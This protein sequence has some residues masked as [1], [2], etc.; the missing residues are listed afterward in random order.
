MT[1][2]NYYYKNINSLASSLSLSKFN[3]KSQT[4]SLIFPYD[5]KLSFNNEDKLNLIQAYKRNDMIL[6]ATIVLNDD[7][8]KIEYLNINNDYYSKKFNEIK[9]LTD[10]EY[11]LLKDAIF[12][13]IETSAY[14]NDKSKII[15]DIHNNLERFNYELKELGFINTKRRCIDNSYWLEAEKNIKK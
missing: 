9:I 13:Y 11:K 1:I 8:I 10:D 7:N 12:D 4:Q 6:Y 3:Y 2:I 5:Y 15:I 14:L